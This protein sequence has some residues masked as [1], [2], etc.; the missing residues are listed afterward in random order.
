MNY[1]TIYD[2]IRKMKAFIIKKL[3]IKLKKSKWAL[4]NTFIKN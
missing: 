3:D 4:L 2:V 1:Y